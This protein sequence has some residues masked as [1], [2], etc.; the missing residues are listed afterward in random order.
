VSLSC[1]T[2][3]RGGG[4]PR[5]DHEKHEPEIAAAGARPL[6]RGATSHSLLSAACGPLC[7]ADCCR[8]AQAATVE[9]VGLGLCLLPV[10]ADGPVPIMIVI[11]PIMMIVIVIVPIMMIVIVIVIMIM[12]V[13]VIMIMIVIVIVPIMIVPIMMRQTPKKLGFP[14]TP[15]T[16]DQLRKASSN[17]PRGTQ[18]TSAV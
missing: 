12:I 1:C 9:H 3:C 15:P 6:T 4:D 10:C 16:R 2:G 13:I 5:G 18:L 14:T 8:V 17:S 11:A 7:C